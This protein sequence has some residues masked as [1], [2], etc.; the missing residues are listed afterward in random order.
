MEDDLQ[1]ISVIVIYD[2][3]I[4]KGISMKVIQEKVEEY[5]EN[6]NDEFTIEMNSED[7]NTE[8]E[9]AESITLA[10]NEVILTHK[11]KLET[12]TVNIMHL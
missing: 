6:L 4:P 1:S 7:G 9:E 12:D 8:E 10:Q 3:I 5:F 11:I 2:A